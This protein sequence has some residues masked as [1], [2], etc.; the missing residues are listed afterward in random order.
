MKEYV[1]VAPGLAAYKLG[2]ALSY[3]EKIT[4]VDIVNNTE[5]GPERTFRYVEFMDSIIGAK[6]FENW[7]EWPTK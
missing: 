4:L 1:Y 2:R 3:N 6:V 7:E 5:I